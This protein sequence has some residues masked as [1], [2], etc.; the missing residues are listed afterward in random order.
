MLLAIELM[1]APHL[2]CGTPPE[3]ILTRNHY[4]EEVRLGNRTHDDVDGRIQFAVAADAEEHT[5]SLLFRLK[6]QMV[7][8]HR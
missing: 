6:P 7:Y 8:I 1:T 3:S 2:P 5:Y 4:L